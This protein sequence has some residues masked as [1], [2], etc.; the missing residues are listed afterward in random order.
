M[1][2]LIQREQRE[3]AESQTIAVPTVGTSTGFMAVQTY[4]YDS[5]NRIEDATEVV[6]TPAGST[7]ATGGLG[8]RIT[9][10][11]VTA[12]V[13]SSRRIR[14]RFRG[15]TSTTRRRRIPSL[16]DEDWKMMNPSVNASNNRLSA[17]DGYQF[18]TAGNTIRDPQNRKFTYDAEQADESRNRRTAPSPER[19]GQYSYDGD[20]RRVK[21]RGWINGQWEETIFVYDA[22]SRLVAEYSDRSERN[23]AGRVSDQRPPRQPA[24]RPTKTAP[25]FQ[26]TTTARTAKKSPSGRIHSTSETRS[27]NSSPATNTTARRIWI[28]LKH[29]TF[30]QNAVGFRLRLFH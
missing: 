4:N 11:T 21:K 13:I 24:S 23:P 29:D 14:R 19:S 16:C 8:N 6:A 12:T 7:T 20:G 1:V 27:A 2:S 28:L 22:S 9:R 30:A 10:S 18:D 15:I 5:L 3:R 26:D 25:S 17:S